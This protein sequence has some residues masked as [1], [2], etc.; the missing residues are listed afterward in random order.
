MFKSILILLLTFVSGNTI[1]EWVLIEDN[2]NQ[3]AYADPT[4]L[5]KIERDDR[6]IIWSMIDL[7]KATKLSDGKPFLSWKTQYEF[8][9]K[10]KQSRILAASMHSGKMGSGEITNSLDFESPQWEK[11][12]PESKGEVLL[13][14]ACEKQ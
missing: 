2:G 3:K 8:D 1:A 5:H 7:N 11:V 9:C 10:E 14:I 6:A 13:K 12:T 4:T